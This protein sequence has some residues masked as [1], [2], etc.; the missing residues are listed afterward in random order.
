MQAY[1]V[2]IDN[3]TPAQSLAPHRC[4]DS[5]SHSSCFTLMEKEA[6]WF[7]QKIPNAPAIQYTAHHYAHWTSTAKPIIEEKI[8]F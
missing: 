7:Q 5:A 2:H 8:I 4:E 1:T 3:A 6:G